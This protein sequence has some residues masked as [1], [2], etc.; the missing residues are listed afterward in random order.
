MVPKCPL[1][2]GS[3]V[4]HMTCIAI[5]AGNDPNPKWMNK[6]PDIRLLT[7]IKYTNPEGKE[8]RFYLTR[9]IQNDCKYLGTFLG[10][11][12]ETLT[13][14]SEKI[15]PKS[16]VCEDILYEWMKRG[17][18]DY[19]VTW[20]G[21]LKAMDDAGLGGVANQLIRALNMHFK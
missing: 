2:G 12:K 15:K 4:L 8:D 9:T 10:I 18:G 5:G 20:A 16:E 17:E 19:V 6:E 11:D 21:L 14:Y 1:F 7:L 13:A 3:I